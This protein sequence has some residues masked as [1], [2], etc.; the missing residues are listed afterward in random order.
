[1]GGTKGRLDAAH[2]PDWPW[3]ALSSIAIVAAGATGHAVV[4]AASAALWGFLLRGVYDAD[5]HHY[6]REER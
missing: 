2:V 3:I 4:A 1:M 6:P 5:Q